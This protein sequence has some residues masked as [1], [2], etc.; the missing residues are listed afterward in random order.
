MRF[1]LKATRCCAYRLRVN[2][3]LDYAWQTTRHT[4]PS[5][6]S[7]TIAA[8]L[9]YIFVCNG[10][11]TRM[12]T[13]ANKPIF[14][15]EAFSFLPTLIST[16]FAGKIPCLFANWVEALYSWFTVSFYDIPSTTPTYE[17]PTVSSLDVATMPAIMRKRS[18]QNSHAGLSWFPTVARCVITHQLPG[19]TATSMGRRSGRTLTP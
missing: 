9:R 19:G 15:L 10:T 1:A 2:D 7:D 5:S 18:S 16:A 14:F 13:Y 11:P 6:R 8:G 17:A 3:A 12:R 4:S